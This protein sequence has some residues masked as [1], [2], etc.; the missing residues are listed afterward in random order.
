MDD[1]AEILY[2]LFN[3]RH[4]ERRAHHDKHVRF[5]SAIVNFGVRNVIG[6]TLVLAVKNDGRS[7]RSDLQPA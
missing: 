5:P 7:Q 2:K 1:F 4:F 3:A 6:V